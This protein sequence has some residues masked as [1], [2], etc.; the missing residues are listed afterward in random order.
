MLTTTTSA[1]RSRACSSAARDDLAGK[2]ARVVPA[3]GAHRRAHDAP[4][5]AGVL[6]Y[7]VT[8]CPEPGPDRRVRREVGPQIMFGVPRVWEKIHAGV[9]RESRRR[10]GEGRR[11]STR[12][13]RPRCRSSRRGLGRRPPTRTRRPGQFLDEV[14]FAAVARAARPRRADAAPSRGAAPI[15]AELLR[16]FRAHR[17]AAVGDLRHVGEHRPDDVGRRGGSSPARS[18]AAMPGMRGA[19]ADD[20]EV[21]LPRRQRVRRLPQRPGEDGRG[22][23]RRRLAAHR[24]H[25]R[26]RRRR[27]P[28]HRRPQEGARSSPP[29]ARTSAPPTSKPRSRRSRSSARRA[30]SATTGRSCRRWSCS[31]PR[32]APAWADAATASS[33]T[34]SP[35]WPSDPK[36]SP[37]SSAASPR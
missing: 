37:R 14:A 16:W 19:L 29:A 23:R 32:S 26:A 33:Y 10:P 6:G 21:D 17:R 15:P 36:S 31:T 11:S 3:D 18:G 12:R 4:L 8:T 35:S 27:L 25:R 34:R 13:S 24:R 7:E 30:P 1:G 28:P 2:R 20:G 22:A 5:P 9:T